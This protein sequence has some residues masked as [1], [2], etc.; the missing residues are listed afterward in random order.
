MTGTKVVTRVVLGLTLGLAACGGDDGPPEGC[1]RWVDPGGDARANVQTMFE[2]AVDGDVLCFTPG[3]YEFDDGVTISDKA[4]ITIRGTGAEREDVLL[5]F[6]GMGTGNSGINASSMTNFTI[7]NMRVVDAAANDVFITDS[8]FVTIRNVSAGW[9]DLRAPAEHGRYAL[10]PVQSSHV[11]VEDSEAFGSVDAGIYVGQTD[12]CIVRNNVAHGNVAGIEIENSTNCEVHNNVARNNSAGILVFELPGLERQGSRTLVHHNEIVDNSEENFAPSDVGIIA[13]VPPGIGL[14]ILAA[15]EVEAHDNT[16]TGNV[17]T[18][19]AV[20]SYVVPIALGA[21]VPDDAEYDFFP[22]SIYLHDNTYSN[23]GQMPASAILLI[24]GSQD[25]PG[26][27][28]EDIVWD[29]MMREGMEAGDVLCIDDGGSYRMAVIDS[30]PTSTS[31]PPF[32]VQST[33]R[34]PVTCTGMTIDP[35]F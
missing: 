2:E 14:M 10:Y 34:A 22:E 8:D 5:N 25:P 26:S 20:V 28:V 11:I 31:D 9:T 3:T 29:G 24:P 12:R 13:L 30:D 19:V 35:E 1:D 6:A 17:S 18:G 32:A 21:P 4:D 15:N 27:T 33:D 7:A 23:N 16:I